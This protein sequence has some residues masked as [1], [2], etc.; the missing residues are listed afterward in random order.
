MTELLYQTDSYLKE[1]DAVLQAVDDA[2]RAVLLDRTA[3]YPG[4]GGQPF[5]RGSLRM[6]MVQYPIERARKGPEGIWLK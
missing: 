4:G 1:F 2:A 3:F 5:D 6:G